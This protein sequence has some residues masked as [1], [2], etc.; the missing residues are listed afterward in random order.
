M[1]VNAAVPHAAGL[2]AMY[3]DAVSRGEG[4]EAAR[5]Y[6]HRDIRYIVNGPP[7]SSEAVALPAIS[8]GL[9]TGLPWLGMYEGLDA[10]LT[11]IEHMHSN[12]DVT[13]FGPR[14]I[15][16]DDWRAAVFGWFGL[17]PKPVG[18]EVR[19]AYSV[20]VETRDEKIIRYQFLENTFD[21][22]LAFRRAGAWSL[23]TDGT[24]TNVPAKG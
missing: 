8:D 5:H 10:V 14:T 11:F 23:A 3:L 16:G 6:F 2:A 1:G 17:R 9:H 4:A 19:I 22:A 21:V 24:L 18:D 7:R 12:L 13:G 15:V 20:L